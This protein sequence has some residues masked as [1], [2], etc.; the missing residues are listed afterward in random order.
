MKRPIYEE[1]KKNSDD[2]YMYSHL[3]KHIIPSPVKELMTSSKKLQQLHWVSGKN[4]LSWS[5][6]IF[7]SKQRII[8][9]WKTKRYTNKRISRPHP[10]KKKEG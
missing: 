8:T 6:K 3:P 2:I 4:H 7:Q 5:I 9:R 10:K 1:D